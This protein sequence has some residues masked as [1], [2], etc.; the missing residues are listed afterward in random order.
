MQHWRYRAVDA[1]HRAR[2]GVLRALDEEHAALELRRVLLR[3]G[4]PMPLGILLEEIEADEYIRDAGRQSREDK[5]RDRASKLISTSQRPPR[6]EVGR[7]PPRPEPKVV[8]PPSAG[9]ISQESTAIIHNFLRP[10]WFWLLITL[11]L[12]PLLAYICL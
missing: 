9:P 11:T 3:E 6:G 10:R 5:L 4:R 2:T 1:S 7:Q 12:V 8:S